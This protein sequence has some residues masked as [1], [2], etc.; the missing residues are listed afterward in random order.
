MHEAMTAGTLAGSP[1]VRFYDQA[2]VDRLLGGWVI[3][4]RQHIVAT[5][6]V[7]GESAHAEWRLVAEKPAG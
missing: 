5:E 7:P 3:L 2:A 6:S 4:S 1:R